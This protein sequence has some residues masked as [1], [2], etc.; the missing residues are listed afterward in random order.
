MLTSLANAQN[1]T[2]TL[3]SLAVI[4][5]PAK[6]EMKQ[7]AAGKM[8]TCQAD[9]RYY[10]L[11][12]QDLHKTSFVYV[13]GGNINLFYDGIIK[14]TVKTDKGVLRNKK[15]FEIDDLRGI[16][17]EYVSSQYASDTSTAFLPEYRFQ[18]DLFLNDK[19]IYCI[20]WTQADSANTPGDDI[21]RDAFFNSL[22]IIPAKN[23]RRQYADLQIGSK[24]GAIISRMFVPLCI[25]LGLIIALIVILSLV[26]RNRRKKQQTNNYNERY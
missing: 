1:Y 11:L 13:A 23:N 8:Y 16:N 19:M 2:V 18:H 17:F 20:Y 3:D 14:G 7:T 24:L 26:Q 5:F 21:K 15:F 12:V 22:K 4:D 25:V 9:A 6:P 10:F